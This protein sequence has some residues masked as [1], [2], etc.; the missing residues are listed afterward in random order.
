LVPQKVDG[1]VIAGRAISADHEADG[2]TRNQPSCMVT[3]EA[4]GVAAALSVKLDTLPRNL[5]VNPLQQ[6]L[7]NLGVKL[8]ISELN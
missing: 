7:R 2:Y 4:A 1:L 5:D 6:L 3:G 8:H